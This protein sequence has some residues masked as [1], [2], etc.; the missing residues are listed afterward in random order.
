MDTEIYQEVILQHSRRPRNFGYL[1]MATHGASGQNASCGD[2]IQIQLVLQGDIIQ[3]IKFNSSACAVCTASAS[4]MTD[5]VKGLVRA[6]ALRVAMDFR[7]MAVEGIFPERLP[8]RLKVLGGIY[9]FPQRV[10]CATLP[11]E[12]LSLALHPPPNESHISP[13]GAA[14]FQAEMGASDNPPR[15][16]PS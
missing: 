15:S 9:Q 8:D 16:L 1:E 14:F 7:R 11:W 5:E 4:I 13:P 2:S 10:R 6:Q 12:T 3:E